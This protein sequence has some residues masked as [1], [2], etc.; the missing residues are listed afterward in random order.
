MFFSFFL[1][2]GYTAKE[3]LFSSCSKDPGRNSG[4]WLPVWPRWKRPAM[5]R[6]FRKAVPGGW[7]STKQLLPNSTQRSKRA[8]CQHLLPLRTPMATQA[9]LEYL[10]HR[11]SPLRRGRPFC[12]VILVYPEIDDTRERKG[13]NRAGEN[14]RDP[15]AFLI[16]TVKRKRSFK[17]KIIIAT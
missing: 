5:L 12:C 16:S 10:P 4:V 9:V 1:G 13:R 11:A 8:I 17:N 3:F 7:R 14:R 2:G 6:K 15:H